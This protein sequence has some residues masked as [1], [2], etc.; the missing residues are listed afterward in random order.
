M[1]DSL[2][3]SHY[4]ICF[5][6]VHFKGHV[7]GGGDTTIIVTSVVTP[8]NLKLITVFPGRGV[9]GEEILYNII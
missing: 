5:T 4:R 8:S 1:R 2:R 9:W 3:T 6:H 7:P